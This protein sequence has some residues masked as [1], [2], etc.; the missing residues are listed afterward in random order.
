MATDPRFL[1]DSDRQQNRFLID[2]ALEDWFKART[3]A[4]ALD[5]LGKARVPAERVDNIA[6]LINNPQVKA[7]EL[8]VYLEHPGV[9]E[10]PLPGVLPKLSLNP[11]SVDSPAPQIGEHNKAIYHDMLGVSEEELSALEKKG[12]I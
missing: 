4:E 3:V 10:M 8:M 12:I 7:R 2:T 1:H 6:D 11:G 5:E 9:G